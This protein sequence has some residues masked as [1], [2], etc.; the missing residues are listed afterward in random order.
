MIVRVF[1]GL[2]LLL[3]LLLYSFMLGSLEPVHTRDA[4]S[5]LVLC[6]HNQIRYPTNMYMYVDFA[7]LPTFK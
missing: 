6:L 4:T 5:Q 7:I 2:L 3:L 1:F